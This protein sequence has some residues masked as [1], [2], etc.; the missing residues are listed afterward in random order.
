MKTY[1]VGIFEHEDMEA[2]TQYCSVP[3]VDLDR[4]VVIDI[5]FVAA[6]GR[7]AQIS[8]I[9]GRQRNIVC[10]HHLWEYP[11]PVSGILSKAKV[12]SVRYLRS[13]FFDFNRNAKGLRGDYPLQVLSPHKYCQG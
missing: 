9:H 13:I 12:R 2:S 10:H 5:F 3:A 4:R 8:H 1:K 11:V 6:D 7:F